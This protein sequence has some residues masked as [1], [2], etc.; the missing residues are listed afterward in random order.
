MNTTNRKLA[1]AQEDLRVAQLRY[2][3]TPNR[4]NA[5]RLSTRKRRVAALAK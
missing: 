2:E 5:R 1:V 3:N 4:R